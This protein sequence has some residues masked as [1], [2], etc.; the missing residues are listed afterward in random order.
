MK[1]AFLEDFWG[2]FD[3]EINVTY[4]ANNVQIFEKFLLKNYHRFRCNTD[5]C[6]LPIQWT[7]FYVNNNY[8]NDKAAL[9]KLQNY[10]DRL[11]PDTKYWTCVQYDDSILND[12]SRIDLLQVNM[13][14]KV[15]VEMPLVCQP[16]PYTFSGEKKYLA[17]FVGS[18][19]HP[20]RNGLERYVNKSGWYISYEPHNITRYC[21]ILSQSVFAICPRGY[22][23]NSFRTTEAMQ[24]GAI[25]IYLSDVFIDVFDLDFKYF[26]VKHLAEDIS[27]LALMLEL[28]PDEE[29]IIR[30]E[31][32]K[33]VYEEYYTYEG[34]MRQIIK[35]LETEY[36]SRESQ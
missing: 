26:G 24:Y 22:G 9:D 31:R 1:A 33:S 34:A 36:H 17:S 29:I 15:G 8:G 10:I 28:I 19:T 12:V 2:N 4:P 5:R 3:T 27:S 30:Q 14:K 25:P 11:N 23:A 13:S 21:E 32:I 20:L 7:P 18:R 35:K 6:Y 16:H